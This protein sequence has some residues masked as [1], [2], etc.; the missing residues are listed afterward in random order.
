MTATG[1]DAIPARRLDAAIA[2]GDYEMVALR[3]ALGV[4]RTLDEVRYGADETREAMVALIDDLARG[5]E[6]GQ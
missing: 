2:A 3:L 6:G 1:P 4:L 5:I